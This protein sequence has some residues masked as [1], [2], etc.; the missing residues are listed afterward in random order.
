MALKYPNEERLY[1]D[2]KK[3]FVDEVL[4]NL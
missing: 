2:E 3:K 4:S 1:T